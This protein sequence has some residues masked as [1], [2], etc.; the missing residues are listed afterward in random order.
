MDQK[1][2]LPLSP[3]KSQRVI[4]REAQKKEGSKKK[5]DERA[6]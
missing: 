6:G 3:A 1:K 4:M 2:S 5:K